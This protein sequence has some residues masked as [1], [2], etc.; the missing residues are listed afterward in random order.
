MYL[1]LTFF[2]KSNKT[3]IFIESA[4]FLAWNAV[5]EFVRSKLQLPLNSYITE[6][7]KFGN[8]LIDKI[9]RKEFWEEKIQILKTWWWTNFNFSFEYLFD[10]LAKNRNCKKTFNFNCFYL[11]LIYQ[12]IPRNCRILRPNYANSNLSLKLYILRLQSIKTNLFAGSGSA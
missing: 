4:I 5:K 6:P 12:S 9:D 7:S 1:L 10:L 2:C 11:G 3:S 8:F